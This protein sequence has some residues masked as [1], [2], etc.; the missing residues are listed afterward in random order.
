LDLR[1]LPKSIESGGHEAD[2]QGQ[3]AYANERQQIVVTWPPI[4]RRTMLRRDVASFFHEMCSLT[5]W[6][7]HIPVIGSRREH[8]IAIRSIL[9]RTDWPGFR[10]ENRRA[11]SMEIPTA[12]HALP[13]GFAI[14]QSDSQ[15]IGLN[16]ALRC[17]KAPSKLT[18]REFNCIAGYVL[19]QNVVQL[20]HV[21][22]ALARRFPGFVIGRLLPVFVRAF[23]H[24]AAFVVAMFR[25]FWFLE[26]GRIA[27]HD[28]L[29]EIYVIGLQS[30]Q[31]V[32]VPDALLIGYDACV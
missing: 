8:L 17:R 7:A 6:I 31:Q 1:H 3:D 4:Q 12:K 2:A 9:P 14:L 16:D 28:A 18:A 19:C 26:V 32:P 22:L 27:T 21:R 25:R 13:K 29:L 5:V 10:A 23:G 30:R 11:G 15:P 20:P 24:L